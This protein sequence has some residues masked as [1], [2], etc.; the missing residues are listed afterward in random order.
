LSTGFV[1][2]Q[3]FTACNMYDVTRINI[4]K[5]DWCHIPPF[6]DKFI[7]AVTSQ[8]YISRVQMILCATLHSCIA[9][10]I[11]CTVRLF[12]GKMHSDWYN[13]IEILQGRWRHGEK[14]RYCYP[15]RLE[16]TLCKWDIYDIQVSQEERT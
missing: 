7:P 9:R 4:K 16:K 11:I 15:S 6:L 12:R 1:S 8:T 10:S 3:P 5:S 13:G 14:V 2:W